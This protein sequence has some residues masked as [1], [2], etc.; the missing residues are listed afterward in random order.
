MPSGRMNST[1]DATVTSCN[2]T[3]FSPRSNL[4]LCGRTCP[5]RGC[6]P[7]IAVMDSQ[8]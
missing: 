6:S 2:T 5:R 8:S 3:G 1:A 7:H 4:Q